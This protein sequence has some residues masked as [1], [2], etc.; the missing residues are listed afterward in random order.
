M[1]IGVVDLD[2]SHPETFLP[3]LREQGHDV[4]GVYGGD[5]VV[6]AAYTAEYARRHGIA[7]VVD[8]PGELIGRV[9]AVFI[10]SVNWDLHVDR[11]RL[12]AEHDIPMHIGKPFAGQARDICRLT[13]WEAG[14]VRISGGS[15]LRWS[16]AVT[17]WREG[18]RR[19]F[20]GLS[21]TYGHP[22]D[23]GIHAYSLLHGLL[24]PGI[25]AARSLDADC[26]RVELR[27]RDDTIALVCV[28]PHGS[29]GFYATVVSAES[30]D[31]I[32]AGSSDIYRPFLD[33]TTRHIAGKRDQGVS[34]AELVE[35]ELAAIAGLASA[36]HDGRWVSL[37]GDPAIDD[38]AFDGAEF[39]ASYRTQRRQQL[40]LTTP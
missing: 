2:T 5:T 1:R 33:V 6:D 27:W 24:G 28:V 35:P 34:F 23:Y 31:H 10:H 15:A 20:S 12:F 16:P 9:D 32:D 4:V 7:E 37:H 29:H 17:A 13:E 11:A 26:R 39:A 38:A 14:G 19:A 21:A 3:V 25:E 40:G 8:H 36:Q 18:Q 22:L 30:V